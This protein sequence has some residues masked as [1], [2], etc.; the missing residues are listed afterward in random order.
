MNLADSNMHFT[1]V[2]I[3]NFP[4]KTVVHQTIRDAIKQIG[5][6]VPVSVTNIML[7]NGQNYGAGGGGGGISSQFED[8]LAVLYH[9]ASPFT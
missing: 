1:G 3:Y 7:E 4:N 6:N 9:H 8:T 2:N 5:T